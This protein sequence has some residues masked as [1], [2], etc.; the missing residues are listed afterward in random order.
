[1]TYPETEPGKKYWD[2]MNN[3]NRSLSE[4]RPSIR[5]ANGRNTQG[6]ACIETTQSFN[7]VWI[8]PDKAEI[9]V[10]GNAAFITDSRLKVMME[11]DYVAVSCRGDCMNRRAINARRFKQHILPQITQQVNH[12]EHFAQLR[13]I[14][15]AFIL[16]VWFK[17]KM[18]DS[19]FQ[20]YIGQKKINGIDINDKNAKQKIYNLYLEAFTKGA[21]NYIKSERVGANGRSPLQRK[22]AK[23]AYFSGGVQLAGDVVHEHHDQSKLV[24]GV[25]A[26][27]VEDQLSVPSSSIP[28]G[29]SADVPEQMFVYAPGSF[30]ATVSNP[31]PHSYVKTSAGAISI[32]GSI[33]LQQ[34]FPGQKD[35]PSVV[36]VPHGSWVGTDG[37]NLMQI[38]YLI[39]MSFMAH[40]QKTTIVCTEEQKEKIIKLLKLG[41]PYD[42]PDEAGYSPAL[43]ESIRRE[44]ILLADRGADNKMV[45]TF[46]DM[47]DFK[48]FYENKVEVN[49]VTIEDKGDGRFLIDD[50]STRTELDGRGMRGLGLTF[51][52]VEPIK[53]PPGF[54]VTFLGVSSGLDPKGLF[55]NE[56]IWVGDQHILVDVSSTT[57]Q[58]LKAL[59]LTPRDITHLLVTHLHEDHVSGAAEYF[60]WCKTNKYPIR[61][62]IEPGM[63][64]LLKEYL[65]FLPGFDLKILDNVEI[66]PFKFNED[67]KLCN[68]ITLGRG[69]SEVVIEISRAFHG[70]P[71]TMFRVN[72]KG[73]TIACSGDHTFDPPRFRQMRLGKASPEIIADLKEAGLDVA[74][75]A[76]LVSQARLEEMAKF[77]FRAN[78][79]GRLPRLIIHDAGSD[80][81]SGENKGNHTSPYDL[82]RSVPKEA[83]PMIRAN[84]RPRLLPDG[85]PFKQAIPMSTEAILPSAGGSSADPAPGDSPASAK[86]ITMPT[87]GDLELLAKQEHAY[88]LETLPAIAK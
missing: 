36:I 39:V 49:G 88:V 69:E 10:K 60:A 83:S 80:A 66:I 40:Q 27:R 30:Q 17:H 86:R 31:N 6:A 26:I 53:I 65:A 62:M 77:L 84:H 76:S 28:S 34:L 4:P 35:K 67:G 12:G 70:T 78:S 63:W 21:Y 58:E 72:Y 51:E 18:Q 25:D 5:S 3:P 2:E 43:I 64:K 14:Y 13:Q 32:G 9:Y 19:I 73:E 23:R 16:A 22:I 82:E 11:E 74:Q 55:N 24:A 50:H 75:G 81:R 15:D 42:L 54:G 41:N 59:G 56:I 33:L 47:V 46:S 68:T 7:K 71:A 87:T 48:V 57:M 45:N 52:G 79:A 85:F 29:G 20:Y 1:M 38:Y 37:A 8:V 44:A 61:L